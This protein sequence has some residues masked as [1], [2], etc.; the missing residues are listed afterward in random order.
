L[1][2]RM[3]PPSAQLVGIY[4]AGLFAV[5][6]RRGF[7]RLGGAVAWCGAAALIVAGLDPFTATQRRSP[8]AMS[9]TMFD[10]GQGDSVLLGLPDGSTVMVD[11]GGA[12]FGGGSFD[13]GGRVL[14]PALWARGVRHLT[15][16]LVTHPDPDHIGGAAAVTADF[17]PR[18]LWQGIAVPTNAPLTALLALAERDAIRT[19]ELR[20]GAAWDAAGARV[21]V[22]HPPPADWERPRVRNDDSVV[23][24]A[25]YGDVALLL[26]GDISAEIERAILP[27]LTPAR[28]RILKVAHHGSRTSSSRELLERWH[29]QIAVISCG[30]GNSFGH[31]APDVLAR[32]ESI[33]ARVYRTD[34]D[35]Q[36]TVTTDGKDVQVRTFTGEKR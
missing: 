35:G 24:E 5:I 9:L 19:S 10:V 22:L 16:L 8:G 32:L 27:Q 13:I 34:L 17:T 30:R 15:A 33:G 26:T 31:P 12:P 1:T 3:P 11:A 21:R 28:I 25:T 36:I 18:E 23:I 4:Y 20:L 7:I 2:A 14:A 29:P 6:W